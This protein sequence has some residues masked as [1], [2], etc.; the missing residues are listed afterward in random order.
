VILY[1]VQLGTE[2]AERT[3]S[4]ILAVAERIETLASKVGGG[5]AIG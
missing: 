4:A 1:A 3:A 2:S 5:P